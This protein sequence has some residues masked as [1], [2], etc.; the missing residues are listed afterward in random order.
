MRQESCNTIYCLIVLRASDLE[1]TSQSWPDPHIKRY[2]TDT[3]PTRR[4]PDPIRILN[5]INFEIQIRSGSASMRLP[6]YTLYIKKYFGKHQQGVA[7]QAHK[8][9]VG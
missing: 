4:D 1:T 6:D 8:N 5:L 3:D 7:K 9:M 2:R